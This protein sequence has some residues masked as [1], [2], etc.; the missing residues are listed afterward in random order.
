MQTNYSNFN[1]RDKQTPS[2]MTNENS[3]SKAEEKSQISKKIPNSPET[4]S[5]R[6][7]NIKE[8]DIDTSNDE[9]LKAQTQASRVFHLPREKN[10]LLEKLQEKVSKIYKKTIQNLPHDQQARQNYLD[11]ANKSKNALDKF[12][13]IIKDIE[14]IS[15]PEDSS[16]EV[17]RFKDSGL[18][19]E[20]YPDGKLYAQ[21]NVFIGKGAHKVVK[22][23][24]DLS[25]LEP[26]VARAT[27]KLHEK[28]PDIENEIKMQNLLDEPE[29]VRILATCSYVG[30]NKTP[31]FGI[32][33]EICDGGTYDR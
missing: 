4:A 19:L 21:L 18:K 24:V 1:Y 6:N 5:N 31:K 11:W 26:D 29:F 30:K 27:I 28:T 13:S 23:S 22:I 33:M 9:V 3:S 8:L 16:K 25:T 15:I 32:M 7:F 14:T 17:L 20:R 2:E 12:V 10:I